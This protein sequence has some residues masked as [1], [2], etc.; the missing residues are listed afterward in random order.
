MTTIRKTFTDPLGA[1]DAIDAAKAEAPGMTVS[2]VISGSTHDDDTGEQT[3]FYVDVVF[4]EAPT[5]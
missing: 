4:S 1:H 3:G 2:Q 5:S